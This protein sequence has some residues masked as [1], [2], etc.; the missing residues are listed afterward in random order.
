VLH[1]AGR[2]TRLWLDRSQGVVYEIADLFDSHAIS[3]WYGGTRKRLPPVEER[4]HV[5]MS[6]FLMHPATSIG[7][8]LEELTKA[9]FDGIE[10]QLG[11]ESKLL[12]TLRLEAHVEQTCNH[13]GIASCAG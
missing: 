8:Y 5:Y 4:I 9:K 10:V 12:H 3:C 1:R 7:G 2:A 6:E 11:H 13:L